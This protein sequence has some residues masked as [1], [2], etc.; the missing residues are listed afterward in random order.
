[1]FK[2]QLYYHYPSRWIQFQDRTYTVH[3]FHSQES[4]PC[5]AA[6]RGV[7]CKYIHSISFTSYR[8]PIFTP[9]WRAAMWIKCI[10]EGQNCQAL[11]GIEPASF[12]PESRVQF[13]GVFI[14][15]TLPSNRRFKSPISLPVTLDKHDSVLITRLAYRTHTS[16]ICGTFML[17]KQFIC[18]P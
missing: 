4:T 17:K 9:G 14:V 3:N 7:T 5:R 10:S 18:C 11:M 1:M 2:A 6:Y 16:A 12:D 13:K 8:V 15:T